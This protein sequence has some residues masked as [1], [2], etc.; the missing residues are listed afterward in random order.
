MR[1]L[2]GLG[3]IAVGAVPARVI[4]VVPGGASFAGIA[5]AAGAAMHDGFVRP[6]GPVF[7]D[8]EI[9]G[10]SDGTRGAGDEAGIGG[11][12]LQLG[13]RVAAHGEKREAV[14]LLNLA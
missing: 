2:A 6:G 14:D 8:I 13:A 7:V 10:N 4:R 3:E 11:D 9:R 12:L 5:L 1:G